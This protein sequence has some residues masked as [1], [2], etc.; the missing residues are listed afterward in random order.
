[1]LQYWSCETAP[2]GRGL[3]AATEFKYPPGAFSVEAMRRAHFADG[4][5]FRRAL[6]GVIVVLFVAQSTF[7]SFAAAHS[8]GTHKEQSESSRHA[9]GAIANHHLP[10]LSVD[11]RHDQR[12]AMRA[13]H[14]NYG[15]V[16]GHDHGVSCC[17]ELC[18][19]DFCI[20]GMPDLAGWLRIQFTEPFI[21]LTPLIKLAYSFE[22]P[23]RM[24]P[25]TI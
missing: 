21:S 6:L 13:A 5:R 8:S 15:P 25:S 12:K 19:A 1:M 4:G 11:D 14:T 23:P 2:E 22:R 3:T 18:T 9:N 17:G 20:T 10:L 24:T 7:A 16:T